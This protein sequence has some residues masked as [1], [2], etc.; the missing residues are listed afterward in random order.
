METKTK[1]EKFVASKKDQWEKLRLL[2]TKI[3]KNGFKSVNDVE[4]REFPRIYRMVCTDLAEAKMLKLSPDVLEYLNNIVGQSHKYLYSFPPLKKSQ[5]RV[6]F[7]EKLPAIISEN[8]YFVIFS[9]IFFLISYIVS[10]IVTYKDPEIAGTI[11]PEQLLEQMKHAYS[12]IDFASG[13]EANAKSMMTSFYIYNN[14]SIGFASFAFG[15]LLGIGTI[16][17]LIY[18]GIV[19]GTISGYIFS[20][21]HG[22]NFLKFV[23]AHSVFE[24][25]GLI[26]TAAAGLKL[27]YTIICAKKYYRKDWL[28]LK[29]NELFTLLT[30]GSLLI[31]CAAFIEGFISPSSLP[32]S[33]KISVAVISLIII[34]YYFL[35]IPKKN[36]RLKI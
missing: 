17:F 30:A 5:V 3:S 11:V 29:K 36:K 4:A 15:V 24:L 19:L 25:F 34:F 31:F 21:G 22:V 7:K 10:F 26:V 13:R 1:S 8:K 6:F 27:G 35:F 32:Y 9:A 23:T 20:L 33:F 2:L 28:N 16:Y 14:V 18:N 12:K